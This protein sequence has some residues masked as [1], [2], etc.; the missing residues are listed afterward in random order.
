MNKNTISFILNQE[1]K[2]IITL[3]DPIQQLNPYYEEYILL[4]QNNK[5]IQIADGQIYH[6]MHQLEEYLKK[7]LANDLQLHTSITQDIGCLSNEYFNDETNF[8]TKDF[9]GTNLWIGFEYHM[10]EFSRQDIG[11]TTWMYNDKN[12]NIILEITPGYPYFFCEPKEEPNYIPYDE[13]KKTYKPYLKT[14]LPKETAQEWLKQAE[15][16]IKIIEDN[17]TAWQKKKK[18]Q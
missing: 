12:K 9:N 13:W 11:T 5:T 1:T 18:E 16:I 8:V 6:N 3:K 2:I 14:I 4:S 17:E 15:F 7:A 10:W